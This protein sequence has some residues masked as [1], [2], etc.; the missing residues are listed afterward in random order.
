MDLSLLKLDFDHAHSSFAEL[1]APLPRT[2]PAVFVR[3]IRAIRG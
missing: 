1:D 3:V 2:E